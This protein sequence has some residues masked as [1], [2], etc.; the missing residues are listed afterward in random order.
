MPE[1]RERLA[2]RMIFTTPVT[3]EERSEGD[4]GLP[5]IVGHAIVVNSIEDGGYFTEEVAPGAV[6]GVFTK[7]SSMTIKSLWNHDSSMPL[8]AFPNSLEMRQDPVGLWTKTKPSDTS[9]A[10]DLVTLLRDNVV[11]QMSFGFYI[12]DEKMVKEAKGAK[13]HFIIKEIDLFDISPVTYP[14]YKGTDVNVMKSLRDTEAAFLQRMAA[15]GT[16]QVQEVEKDIKLRRARA[17]ESLRLKLR[18]VCA[19]A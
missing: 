5:F 16:Q 6:A 14:F 9:Y 19:G 18:R 7:A 8:G 11:N 2:H 12:V 10:R 3:A 1:T 4:A 17:L 13:P 15:H